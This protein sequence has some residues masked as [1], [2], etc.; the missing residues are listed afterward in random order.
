VPTFPNLSP[1]NHVDIDQAH[2]S[3]NPPIDQTSKMIIIVQ[4]LDGFLCRF[5][6]DLRPYLLVQFVP[7]LLIPLMAVLTPSKYSHS[8]IWLWASAYYVA[9][10]LAESTDRFVFRMT[11]ENVSGHT[12]KHLLAAVVPIYILVM[13]HKR[14]MLTERVSEL[15]RWGWRRRREGGVVGVEEEAGG[16]VAADVEEGAEE[17]K[18]LLGHGS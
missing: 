7:L 15:E 6:D 8:H 1:Q 13:L 5:T 16:S 18:G 14:W 10:K 12:V 3:A 17:K 2:M 11:G 4:E 9:A